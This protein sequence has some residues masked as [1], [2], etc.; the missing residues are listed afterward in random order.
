MFRVAAPRILNPLRLGAGLRFNSTGSLFN[1]V[2]SAPAAPQPVE[3]ETTEK[4][5]TPE[6]DAKLQAYLHPAPFLAVESL[7]SPL[8]R[9]LY[10]M[11]VKKNG[12]FINNQIMKLDGAEYKLCLSRQEIEALEPSVYLRSYRI[13]SS[14]KKTN[15]VLRALKNMPLKKA[16]TQLHFLQ[17]KVARPLA[18]LLERGVDDAKKMGYNP[19][20]LYV[21]ESWVHTDGNWQ[22]RPEFKGRGRS[23]VI[24]HRYVSVR[25]LLKSKQTLN[26]L[27]FEK[28]QKLLKRPVWNNITKTKLIGDSGQYKW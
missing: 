17:K 20:D 28:E 2:S 13:K 15:I 8:K 11:N 25:F 14:V 4:I 16:I 21:A 24:L 23:G 1:E 6:Q 18:E 22:K 19:N 10:N 12:F 9:E 3:N 5:T 7:V 26:R 27:K